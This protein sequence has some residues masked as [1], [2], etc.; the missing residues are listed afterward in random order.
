MN[1]NIITNQPNEEYTFN[2][3]KDELDNLFR[4]QKK[5]AY[6][7]PVVSTILFL[8]II[9]YSIIVHA[10]QFWIG[11]SVGVILF[12]IISY[13]KGYFALNKTWKTNAPKI[14]E[15]TYEYQIYDNYFILNLYRNNEKT[16]QSKCYFEDIGQIQKLDKWLLLQFNGQA[17]ILRE[18]DLKENSVF[19]TYVQKNSKN[20]K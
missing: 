5:K 12:I 10:D 17:F 2:F 1:D 19:L 14:A 8:S 18:N 7:N 15:T 9:I 20:K 13:G 11:L 4:L 16:R 3:T 6:T